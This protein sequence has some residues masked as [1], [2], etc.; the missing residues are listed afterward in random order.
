MKIIVT[1]AAGF[2]GSSLVD[3]LLSDGHDV[4]GIDNFDPF[5]SREI[6]EANLANAL[7]HRAFA[8][9]ELDI[10]TL[11]GFQSILGDGRAYDCLVH[12]AAKAG[13]RPSI[14]DPIGYQEANVRGTQNMLEFAR[15]AGIRQFIF[16]SSSSVYGVN[17]NVPWNE[18][19]TGLKPISPYASTKV[20]GELLGHVYAHLHGIRFVALRFFTVYGPR[21]RP[22]LAIRKFTALLRAGRAVP[23]YGNG[24]TRRDYTYIADIVSGIV[25]AIRY[26]ATPFEVINLGNCQTVSL[27]E[28]VTTIAATLNVKAGL[29]YQ[30]DQPGDVPQTWA[31]I[32]KARD[33]LGY[34]PA[35]PFPV[36]IR[37]FVDWTSNE[38]QH[39]SLPAACA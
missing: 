2:I 22:D 12:L 28:M 25:S 8:L 39:A 9:H 11:D 18:S 13:V 5:Y 32:T 31:D 38:S 26:T 23:F 14:A 35:T 24:S 4:V 15:L 30:P 29:D 10:R 27:A 17:P 34:I 36:G 1:G 20:S 6:K 21:Q 3:R 7:G 16:A 33:L 37:R 19:D